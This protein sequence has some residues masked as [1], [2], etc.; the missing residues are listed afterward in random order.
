MSGIP[1]FDMEADAL[2]G[3]SAGNLIIE[4]EVAFATRPSAHLTPAD[5]IHSYPVKGPPR[6]HQVRA[7]NE[8]NLRPGHCYFVDP[9]GGKTYLSIAEAGRL[10]EDGEISGVLVFAPN[11]VHAQWVEEQFPRWC[12]LETHL[13][14]NHVTPRQMD[15]WLDRCGPHRLDVLSVNYET[16][17]T[18]NG[19]A[20]IERFVSVNPDFLLIVDESHKAKSP[21]A[22]QTKE[23][24]YWALRAKYRRILSGTPILR[25]LEDLWSQYEICE[26]GLAWPHEPIRMRGAKVNTYGFLGF[27]THYCITRK[28]PM[29][30]RAEII[31]GYRNESQLRERV[32]PYVTRI[33]SDEFAVQPEPDIMPLHVPMSPE[34]H[35]AYNQMK[36]MLITQ[37][38]A[39]VVTAAN[40]L[41]QM[42][43]LMQIASGFAY[44]DAD[45]EDAEVGWEWFGKGKIHAAL[46]LI[47]QLD[48]PVIVWAPFRALQQE[49]L[50]ELQDRNDRKLWQERPFF[51]Y[52]E[53]MVDLW[54][55]TRNGILL[56]N[57]ASG[58]GVGLNLQ[59]AAANIYLANT[60]AAEARWQSIKRTDRIGQTRQVRVWDLIAPGTLEEEVMASLARKEKISRRNIDALREMLTNATHDR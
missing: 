32:A 29:N 57:Q 7:L 16:M 44:L 58:M 42:N 50:I 25:G 2:R 40:A 4:D 23:T 55:A 37:I 20:L 36:S 30:A 22:L 34:Q 5:L 43:K 15:V 45:D 6:S 13:T 17:R 24:M 52:G 59:H 8:A 19:R 60:F 12:P 14:H 38:D 53:G 21:R 33:M 27:R 46:D 41:V 51:L 18:S 3:L 26:P 47:E 28:L 39:G 10:Y 56:G 48:E 9:G 49:M 35:R 1:D 31:V 54:K 11:G